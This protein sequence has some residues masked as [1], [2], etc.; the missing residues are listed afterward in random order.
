MLAPKSTHQHETAVILKILSSSFLIF[1]FLVDFSGWI[2]IMP[3]PCC[4]LCVTCGYKGWTSGKQDGCQF[5]QSGH[6]FKNIH[7]R[8]NILPAIL[9]YPLSGSPGYLLFAAKYLNNTGPRLRLSWVKTAA[10]F[11]QCLGDDA[12]NTGGGERACHLYIYKTIFSVMWS[13]DC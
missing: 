4:V 12:E 1:L 13:Q 5:R 8:R 9:L 6:Q 7:L 11:W 2:W 3:S 10:V